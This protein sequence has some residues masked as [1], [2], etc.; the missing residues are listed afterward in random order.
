MIKYL[1]MWV[2]VI[3]I[4]LFLVIQL[5]IN[6]NNNNNTQFMIAYN[7]KSLN[8]WNKKHNILIKLNNRKKKQ[9]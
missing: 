1:C 8:Y 4:F 5:Y 2:C 6:N 3:F 7:K 9:V